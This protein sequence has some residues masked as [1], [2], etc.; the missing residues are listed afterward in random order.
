MALNKNV[1]ILIIHNVSVYSV[2]QCFNS[3]VKILTIILMLYWIAKFQ[4]HHTKQ[5]KTKM[6]AL[7]DS[8]YMSS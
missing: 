7:F 4:L 8:K 5:N 1:S 6:T 2:K 3:N